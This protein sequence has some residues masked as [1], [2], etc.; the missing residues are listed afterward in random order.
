MTYKEALERELV[1]NQT[2][3]ADMYLYRKQMREPVI[4]EQI[5]PPEGGDI[6]D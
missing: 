5:D 3:A 1:E 4:R 2:G 6:H